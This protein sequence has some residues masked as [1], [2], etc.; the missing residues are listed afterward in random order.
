MDG[1]ERCQKLPALRQATDG[2]A[3]LCG[4]RL[5]CSLH[6]EIY[7]SSDF[8]GD[9]APAFRFGLIARRS[10]RDAF[11]N[12]ELE[13]EMGEEWE[14]HRRGSQLSW[15]QARELARQGFEGF[16]GCRPT[17]SLPRPLP[18]IPVRRPTA[19]WSRWWQRLCGV[20]A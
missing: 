3:E 5:W 12:H 11:W 10:W 1:A 13:R 4:W 17:P 18:L 16:R 7:P 2:A 8:D 9:L 14:L 6:A 15:L 20:P 19:A